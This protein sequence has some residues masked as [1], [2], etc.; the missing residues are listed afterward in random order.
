MSVLVGWGLDLAVTDPTALQDAYP[1]PASAAPG[2]AWAA[3][4]LTFEFA[5]NAGY[6]RY[7]GLRSVREGQREG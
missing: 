7:A 2:V 6:R 4:G 5:S 1:I 3:L